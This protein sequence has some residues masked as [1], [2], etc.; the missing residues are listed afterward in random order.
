[1]LTGYDALGFRWIGNPL[2]Y[3]RVALAS[4]VAFVFSHNIGLS[5]LGGNAVRYR[6]LTSF[7]VEP[8]DIAAA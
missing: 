3:P 8:G 2:A 1:V 4:F 6:I 7:E 5:F